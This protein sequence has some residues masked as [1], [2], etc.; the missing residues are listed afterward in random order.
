MGPPSYI[1]SVFDRNMI[2]RC[3]TVY[4][5]FICKGHAV[6]EGLHDQFEQM[7]SLCIVNSTNIKSISVRT[8]QNSVYCTEQ[9]ASTYLRSL[10]G[11][12]LVFKT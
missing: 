5:V 4:V 2:M 1:W 10:W 3:M 11:S 6:P 9:N 7:S 12:Q 8:Q